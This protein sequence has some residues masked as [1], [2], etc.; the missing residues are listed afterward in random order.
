[1]ASVRDQCNK[2]SQLNNYKKVKKPSHK[3][4]QYSKGIN[5]RIKIGLR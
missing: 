5:R 1:M 4:F 2:V 3:V